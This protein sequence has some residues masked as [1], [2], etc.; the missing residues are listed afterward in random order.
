V[1]RE[2][3]VAEAVAAGFSSF[4][5]LKVRGKDPSAFPSVLATF[6]ALWVKN[7]RHV[8]GKASS[9]DV[10][11]EAA[12]QRRGFHLESQP[13]EEQWNDLLADDSITPIPD[14]VS[15]KMDWSEF[16]K[17]QSPRHRRII[18]LLGM[19]HAAKCVAHRFRLSPARVTQLRKEWRRQWQAFVGETDESNQT[20]SAE[21][22]IRKRPA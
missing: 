20:E 7:G 12:Q 9:R 11:S 13:Q 1:D 21:P 19:G 8:G 4:V 22:A 2:K 3:A 17:A 10:M 16:L 18:H 15:F 6:A 14:Q 5:R